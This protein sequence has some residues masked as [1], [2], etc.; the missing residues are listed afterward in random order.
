MRK[1]SK[2]LG[3]LTAVAM[4]MSMMT[5]AAFAEEDVYREPITITVFDELANQQSS[6][7]FAEILKDKFNVELNIISTN[8]DENA[9]QTRMAAGELGD[10]I[11]FGDMSDHL[12]AAMNA[13]LLLDWNELDLTPYEN[14]EAYT[15][16][17]QAKLT[18][19]VLNAT[20][21]DGVWG[22]GHDIGYNR[23]DWDV[24]TEP[25]YGMQVR[26]DAYVAA[27]MPELNT[28]QDL[29]PF[30]QALQDAVPEN[31]DGE[32]V[33]AYGGFA[34]WEDCVMKFTW[35]IMT[36][37]GYAEQDYLGVNWGTGDIVNPLEDDSLY[38]Q[39]L[40]VNNELYR[41]GL[42]DPESISQ[43]Y[44]TYSTKVDA[45]R[46]LLGL[47][48]WKMQT[49]N[50][51]ERVAKGEGYV[52]MIPDD[53]A[54]VVNGTAT[55]GGNRVWT[56]GANCAYPERILEILDWLC[57]T[58][59]IMTTWN[60]P[61]GL[62]WDYDENGKPYGTDFGWQCWKDGSNT[63][64]PAEY[65]GGTYT[66]GQ[67]ALN[68]STILQNA[69]DPEGGFCYNHDAWDDGI[70]K[71]E[72]AMINAWSELYAGGARTGVEYYRQTG[73]YSLHPATMYTIAAKSD[74]LATMRAQF[75]PIMKEYSWKCV[76]AETDEE[77]EALW[78]EMVDKCKAFGYDEV[79]EFYLGEIQ[80]KLDAIAAGE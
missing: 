54:P 51:D 6:G 52:T 19:Y 30:L 15:L 79:T 41:A 1:L 39:C 29:V 64:M 37:Y 31:A 5:V 34:D 69:Y 20:G 65:G 17:S 75:A 57:S 36:W 42:F 43:N 77:F 14:I 60:G 9:W 70:A 40:K 12:I 4:L 8:L 26:W 3:L 23:T 10:L 71:L 48:G 73:K 46:Y 33:Y 11:L 49:Y 68:N 55:F 80:N 25:N 67:S 59:G 28:L 22:F 78:T 72:N 38:Y 45:G 62:C 13:N 66:D 7:W 44:D 50:S 16:D 21:I 76:Y 27:G 47:W 56:I 32:K 58:D 53:A 2:I 61:Q 74:D 63:E 24:I 35:D 18:N